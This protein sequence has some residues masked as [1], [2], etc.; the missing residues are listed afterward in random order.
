VFKVLNLRDFLGA[1][2]L[3]T[4]DVPRPVHS[5]AA[6]K[7][8]GIVNSGKLQ[9]FECN[10]FR[11]EKLCY[12]FIGRPAYKWLND[13]EAS[14]WQC[15]VVFVLKSLDGLPIK[16][17]YPFD[18]GAFSSRLLPDYIT[19]FA[20]DEYLLGNDPALISEVIGA[21][22]GTMDRYLR[23]SS[24]SQ[25]EI[26]NKL[27]LTARHMKIEA[28]IRL[29]SERSS[30]RFDDRARTVEVQ[31]GQDI[32]I[33]EK[34]IV[35]VVMPKR[36]RGEPELHSYFDRLGCEIKYYEVFP[37]SVDQY[38]GLVYAAVEEILRAVGPL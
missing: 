34:N 31:I 14:W 18:S 7:I 6:S 30:I 25:E 2:N 27:T 28:L 36:F 10:V 21:M 37:I 19:T 11:P 32:E 23:G 9:A 16:R 29:Y 5:T 13:G 17:I 26:D 8:D 3:G 24:R 15:P 38:Y 4:S 20:R 33:N 1:A 22:Y 12:L 35:G